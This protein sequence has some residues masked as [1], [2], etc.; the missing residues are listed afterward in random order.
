MKESDIQRSMLTWLELKG[1]FAFP[2]KNTGT[3]DPTAKCFRSFR[4]IKGIPDV[5]AIIEGRFIGIE[6]KNEKGK[7]SED[8]KLVEQRIVEEGGYYIVVRSLEELET[9]IKEIKSEL[10][11]LQ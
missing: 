2:I 6:V 11:N 1:I 7:Q 3:Y 8:Q 5:V 10:K 4:G 9:D